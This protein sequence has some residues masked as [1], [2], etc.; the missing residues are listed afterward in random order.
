MSPFMES[1]SHSCV[2]L[3]KQRV[4]SPEG[5]SVVTWVDSVPFKCYPALDASMQSRIA[6]MD[7][8][9]SVYNIL[10]PQDVPAEVGDYFRDEKLNGS[11]F[12]ITSRPEEKMTPTMSTMSVKFFTAERTA[13]P[14]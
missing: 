5:G 3:D 2:L 10:I 6:Q 4:P 14:G 8:V 7:G 9:T 13:L 12:R 1:I 11:I